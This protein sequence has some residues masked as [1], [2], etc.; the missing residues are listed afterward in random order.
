VPAT[1]Q[2]FP[3]ILH[4]QKGS[5]CKKQYF[6]IFKTNWSKQASATSKF[7]FVAPDR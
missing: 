5:Q 7:S 1:R 6:L 2:T 4:R 3:I